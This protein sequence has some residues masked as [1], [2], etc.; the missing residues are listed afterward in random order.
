VHPIAV[1]HN[2]RDVTDIFL[3]ILFYSFITMLCNITQ[4]G[5][6]NSTYGN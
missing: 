2:S 1:W 4:I 5:T 3:Q 6:L